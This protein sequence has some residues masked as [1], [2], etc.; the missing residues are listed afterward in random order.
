MTQE[1]VFGGG[2]FWCTQAA[3]KEVEGVEEVT[4][5]YAGGQTEDPSYKEVCTGETG[6]AEVVKVEYD[7]EEVGFEEILRIFFRTHDPTTEDRQGPDV[8]SQYRSIILYRSG[9]DKQVI[10]AFID[11]I[12]EKY[13]NKIVTEV[14]ELDEFYAA[15][16]R[17]QD[18]FEKNPGD[19]YCTMHAQPKVDKVREMQQES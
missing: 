17:H 7:E 9:A 4:P 8:G 5:G 6:H 14:E 3:F 1:I 16:E 19:A 18:Y 12:R 10:E 13:E 2:C 11:S 15:E